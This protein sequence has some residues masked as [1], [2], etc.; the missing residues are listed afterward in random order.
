MRITTNYSAAFL[1]FLSGS[2]AST[3]INILTGV[4][5]GPT[6]TFDAIVLVVAG[7]TIFAISYLVSIVAAIYDRIERLFAASAPEALTELERAAIW[8]DLK[9][10]RAKE[11]NPLRA[12]LFV[13]S[14]AILLI[15]ILREAMLQ[16]TP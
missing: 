10:I 12:A 11:V 2:I 3:G 15:F 5:A 6:R 4:L 1:Y 8:E 7:L 13:P 14:L 9:E 16:S